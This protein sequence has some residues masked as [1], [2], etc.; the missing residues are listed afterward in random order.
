MEFANFEPIMPNIQEQAIKYYQENGIE[1]PDNK[2]FMEY[3]KVPQPETPKVDFNQTMIQNH[4]LYNRNIEI[5]V[6]EKDLSADFKDYRIVVPSR[7]SIA[8]RH[9]NPGNLMFVNQ[10][11][12]S[13]GEAKKGGGFWARYKTLE[14]GF[15]GLMKQIDLEKQR[16]HTVKTFLEKYAPRHENDTT[17][18]INKLSNKL[19]VAQDTNLIDIPT[20]NIARIIAEIESGT[21]LIP[22]NK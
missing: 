1:L 11:L 21:K 8:G 16:G 6:P 15:V 7:A 12:A 4:P 17:N 3:F 20:L 18:Y 5:K 2:Y 22:K 19:G 13:K 9:N 14:E 10:S